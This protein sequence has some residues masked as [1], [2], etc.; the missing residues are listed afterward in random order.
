MLTSRGVSSTLRRAA[1][2][3]RAAGSIV[4]PASVNGRASAGARRPE[5][6]SSA[7]MR[8]ISSET[9]NGFVT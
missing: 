8:A 1:D 3:V 5:R 9:E 6:R 4:Q 2:A 7:S